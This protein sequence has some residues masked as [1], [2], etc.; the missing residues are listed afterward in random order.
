M[1]AFKKSGILMLILAMGL[2]MTSCLDDG[3]GGSSQASK[4]EVIQK[5]IKA[6][7]NGAK[8]QCN[9]ESS[10]KISK[11]TVV[12]PTMTDTF[13]MDYAEPGLTTSGTMS[14]TIDMSYDDVTSETLSMEM[15]MDGT[16]TAVYQDFKDEGFIM[17]G[18]LTQLMD[19]EGSGVEMDNMTMVLTMNGSI[20][21]SGEETGTIVFTNLVLTITV[22]DNVETQTV[23]GSVTVDGVEIDIL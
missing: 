19:M 7:A 10:K 11:A 13:E 22:V 2:F 5:M 18:T 3:N 6:L 4:E 23:T 21:M 8:D 16:I 12:M 9:E 15:N 1:K 20:K 14:Y 17:N